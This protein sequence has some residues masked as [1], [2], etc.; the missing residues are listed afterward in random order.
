MVVNLE[1]NLPCDKG[2]SFLRNIILWVLNA[3]A[4]LSIVELIVLLVHDKG[5]RL[6]DMVGSTQVIER[7][8]YKR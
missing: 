7:V 1:N 6:G 5:Q 8:H 2:K 4:G 3:L